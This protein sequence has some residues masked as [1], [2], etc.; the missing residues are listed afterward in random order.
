MVSEMV[1]E[2]SETFRKLS[3]LSE[4][5]KLFWKP[6]QMRLSEGRQLSELL[7]ERVKFPKLSDNFP[8]LSEL[9]EKGIFGF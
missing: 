7:S 9:S 4:F 5:G 1:S 6:H 3:E 2:L 8:K